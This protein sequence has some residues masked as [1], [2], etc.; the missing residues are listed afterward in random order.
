MN[1]YVAIWS[2]TTNISERKSL[3]ETIFVFIAIKMRR[4]YA[5]AKQTCQLGPLIDEE[6]SYLVI[7]KQTAL[8]PLN[9]FFIMEDRKCIRNL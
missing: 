6:Q 7:S 8:K 2:Y 5:A 9:G 1:H 3:C 4:R